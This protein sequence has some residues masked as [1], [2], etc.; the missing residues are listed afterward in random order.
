MHLYIDLGNTCLKW[1]LANHTSI[2]ITGIGELEKFKTFID[3]HNI[4]KCFISCSLGSHRQQTLASVQAILPHNILLQHPTVQETM[5]GLTHSYLDATQL[6]IDRW[7]AM[8]AVWHTERQPSLIIDSGSAL[9]LDAIDNNGQH[10]GGYILPG[11]AMHYT[12]LASVLPAATNTA[13]NHN[14]WQTDFGHTTYECIENGMHSLYLNFLQHQIDKFSQGYCQSRVYIT[15][16]NGKFLAKK[17]QLDYA[18][19]LVL[20][21][22]KTYFLH[23]D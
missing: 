6:G 9:T 2:H 21:G 4:E 11:I 23:K 17:L 19:N 20:D 14:A 18:Q 12:N 1:Q 7:L 3:E 13:I 5:L 22:L 10:L 15:G 8:L 16:G